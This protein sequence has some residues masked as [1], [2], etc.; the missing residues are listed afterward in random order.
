MKFLTNDMLNQFQRKSGKILLLCIILL[1]PA[2]LFS[3]V[4]LKF[5]D[6]DELIQV[7]NTHLNKGELEKG[8]ELLDAN[9]SS[10]PYDADIKML[11]GKYHV[12]KKQYDKARFELNKALEFN[13]KNVDVKNLLITVETETKRYSSAICYVNELLEVNPYWKVLWRKKIEL[14]RLLGNSV[15]AN[16]LLKR[17]AQIF[18]N[19]VELKEDISYQMEEQIL[20]LKKEGKIDESN[21]LNELLIKDKPNQIA[22]YLELINNY[23]KVGNY[24]EAL[25]TTERGLNR[26]PNHYNL[27]EKKIAILD[28]H[29]QYDEILLILQGPNKTRFPNLYSYY[30][31]E[32]ARAAKDQDP[33]VLYGKI[34]TQNPANEEAFHVVLND[35][36]A[37]QQYDQ[38]LNTLSSYINLNGTNKELALKELAIYR[39]KGD[40]KKV[41]QLSN[42]LYLSYPEDDDLKYLYANNLQEDIKDLLTSQNYF[43]VIPKL[44]TLQELGDQDQQVFAQNGLFT[45]YNLSGNYNNAYLVLEQLMN[46]DPENLNLKI[47]SI[48]LKKSLGQIDLAM[49]E[50]ESLLK[51]NS[52]DDQYDQFLN[53]Y[54]ELMAFAVKNSNESSDYPLALSH[55]ERWLTAHPQNKDALM[56]AINLSYQLKLLDKMLQHST[57]AI[58]LYPNDVNFKL[59]HSTASSLQGTSKASIYEELKAAVASTPYH[60]KVVESFVEHSL[61]YA[62]EQY[63]LKQENAVLEITAL[64]LKFKPDHKD[65]N[66]LRGLA[67]EK[68]KQFDSAYFYQKFY[69]PSIIEE[70]DFIKHLEYLNLRHQPNDVGISQLR[71]RLGDEHSIQSI[72][73]LE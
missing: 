22:Y 2:F 32:A 38:A 15:E 65:L 11:M 17:L 33:A 61:Q 70:K 69:T 14:Y 23:I 3:Q 50:Y 55:A 18:P 13:N 8:R 7:I 5:N 59:K 21:E 24:D 44:L 49:E 67:F 35:E 48:Q 37:N 62:E 29:K 56:Y 19:D 28:H 53:G 30:L 41:K 72:S 64:A 31:T 57:A 26:F 6:K 71:S 9:S 58:E 46:N 52:N 60:E 47:K 66:Y 54:D 1:Y 73:S 10:Y 43:E 42:N 16:R 27:I 39:L 68:L 63:K 51:F 20:H 12:L 34:L 36:I 25:S 40:E 4:A 45:A